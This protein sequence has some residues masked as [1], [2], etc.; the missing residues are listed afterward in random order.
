MIPGKSEEFYKLYLEAKKFLEDEQQKNF[1]K[2][3][4]YF[5]TGS[6]IAQTMAEFHEH[7]SN[8]RNE[9]IYK[10]WL[11]LRRSSVDEIGDKL[12]YCG[13]TDKCSC[14]DP[15]ETLFKESV[16]RGTII[17]NDPIKNEDR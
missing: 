7:K 17:L 3:G 5:D 1:D 15:G 6:K 10:D 2:H 16:E 4:V 13:H 9:E 14:A 12:C 8:K 11:N